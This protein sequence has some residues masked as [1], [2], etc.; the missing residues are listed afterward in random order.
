MEFPGNSHRP[1]ARKQLLP[2]DCSE[3][4][5]GYVHRIFKEFYGIYFRRSE[6]SE[7]RWIFFRLRGMF[8][9][10]RRILYAFS[11]KN[12]ENNFFQNFFRSICF[13]FGRN[14]IDLGIVKKLIFQKVCTMQYS[15]NRGLSGETE[16]SVWILH[17][18]RG[19]FCSDSK[20]LAYQCYPYCNL[21]T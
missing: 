9:L 16:A 20:L 2:G 15:Q 12:R 4:Y 13:P 1:Q 21:P 8:L 5:K 17:P 14:T 18:K 11:V 6:Y 3:I 19:Y 10:F 7:V